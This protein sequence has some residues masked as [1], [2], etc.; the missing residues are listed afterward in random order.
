MLR[1][2]WRERLRGWS[3]TAAELV[4]ELVQVI[5]AL[6]WAGVEP[7][8]RL[9][10]HYTQLGVLDRPARQGKEAHYAYRQLVQFLVARWLLQDGW[11]LT[12]IAEE[13]S[14][15]DTPTLL[16]MLPGAPQNAAQSLIQQLKQ[17]SGLSPSP[18]LSPSPA[19]DPVSSRQAELAVQRARLQ[20]A[21]PALGNASGSVV[22]RER[23]QLS[24][25]EWCDVLID[26]SRLS[27]LSTVEAA[28]LGEALTAALVEAIRSPAGARRA[29]AWKKG[30]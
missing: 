5:D 19:S 17:Q 2:D 23:V 3:G 15:R 9:I 8:V 20:T 24:L 26:T 1:V 10:R 30:D 7:S 16:A 29:P 11:T 13:T 12:K 27:S 4:D 18:P 21:L 25:T 28:R 22:T 6:P 14:S